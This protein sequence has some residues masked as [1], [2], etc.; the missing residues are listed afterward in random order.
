MFTTK[1]IG[2]QKEFRDLKNDWEDLIGRAAACYIFDEFDWINM[3]LEFFGGTGDLFIVLVYAEGRLVGALPLITRSHGPLRSLEFIGSK[4]ADYQGF[5]LDG[6]YDPVPIVHSAIEALL[7]VKGWDILRLSKVRQDSPDLDALKGLSAEFHGRLLAGCGEHRD[8]APYIPMGGAWEAHKKTIKAK[9]LADTRR[10]YKRLQEKEGEA[11]VLDGS[12]SP[13]L[14]Q[15]LLEVLGSL[16]IERRAQTEG[17]SLFQ[18]ESYK[19]FFA[20]MARWADAKGYLRL[21]GLECGGKIIAAHLGFLYKGVFNYYLPGFDME[22]KPYGAG[23]LLL[24]DLIEMSAGRGV[25]VFDFMLGEEPYKF[26]WQPRR[27]SLYYVNMARP[28]LQG[29]A[30]FTLFNNLFILYKKWRKEAW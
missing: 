28:T 5:L 19:G 2:T 24:N 4:L 10:R 22:Y 25:D 26:D 29:R 12:G 6:K 3:W 23:R 18:H 1:I 21:H 11:R 8:C 27:M 9:F 13:E 7:G 20:S 15:R 16:H 30:V 14:T 17:S